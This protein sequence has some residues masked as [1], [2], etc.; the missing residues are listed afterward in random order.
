MTATQIF[1]RL[2]IIAL[3]KVTCLKKAVIKDILVATLLFLFFPQTF[4]FS[5]FQNA[6]MY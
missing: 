5:L 6:D 4:V 2:K 3:Q 1:W